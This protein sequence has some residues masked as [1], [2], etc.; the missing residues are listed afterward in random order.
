MDLTTSGV[1]SLG[2]GNHHLLSWSLISR[3]PAWDPI[4]GLVWDDVDNLNSPYSIPYNTIT[5]NTL[6][7]VI[8]Y[9]T[10]YRHKVLCMSLLV[11]IYYHTICDNMWDHDVGYNP[12]D[13]ISGWM[14]W[15]WSGSGP[16]RGLDPVRIWSSPDMVISRSEPLDDPSDL[17]PSGWSD[18]VRI[19]S[20]SGL[21]LVI[22]RCS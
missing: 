16:I 1:W 13:L 7:Y 11:I 19:R 22:L 17:T 2:D 5:H 14:V 9:N 18:L 12:W 20:G 8:M 21:D 15:I 10:W 4:W 3:D 6:Y